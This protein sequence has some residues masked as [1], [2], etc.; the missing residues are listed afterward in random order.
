MDLSA[1]TE[2][3]PVVTSVSGNANITVQGTL[4]VGT[5]AEG[6]KYLTFD[7]KNEDGT[8][9]NNASGLKVVDDTLMNQK[10][11]T[12]ETWVRGTD[13]GGAGVMYDDCY[14]FQGP[15]MEGRAYEW[16][17]GTSTL[18]WDPLG[19]NA[20]YRLQQSNIQKYN[21]EWKHLAFTKAYDE[22][23]GEWTYALYI[24][25]AKISSAT[26]AAEFGNETSNVLMIGNNQGLAHGF[27]GDIATFKVYNTV[28]TEA[29][30]KASYKA[31]K[32][33][34]QGLIALGE[35]NTES[36]T[37]TATVDADL[38]AQN[39][40]VVIA[41]YDENDDLVQVATGTTL[42]IS[43]EVTLKEGYRARCFVWGSKTD[44]KPLTKEA[45]AYCL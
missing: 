32:E 8:Y 19:D 13:F 23:A 42:T 40:F 36:E 4:A 1:Y 45:I 20:S 5:T 34:M 25:G 12:V 10:A 26:K 37:I 38:L 14:I 21:N 18:W 3:N 28:L 15:R 9:A 41:L 24:D 22:T 16:T 27:E 29:Q 43:G 44:L 17:D 33:G 35:F 2:E 7:S 30:I 11:M 6:K 31:D 39:P